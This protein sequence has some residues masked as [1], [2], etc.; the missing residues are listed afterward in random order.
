MNTK[1]EK[2]QNYKILKYENIKLFTNYNFINFTDF[3]DYDV[4]MIC[5]T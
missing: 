3:K 1:Q 5:S 4:Y 2:G